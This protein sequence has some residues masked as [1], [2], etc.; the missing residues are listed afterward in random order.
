MEFRKVSFLAA[1]ALIGS[2][3]LAQPAMAEQ[4]A[5]EV[6]GK[7]GAKLTGDPEKGK[8]VFNQCKACHTLEPGKNLTGPTLHGIIGRTAG[9]VE[10]YNYSTANKES[11]VVWTEQNMF[12][13]L[14]NPR[15]W[16]KGTKMAFAGLRKEQDRAD[17][18]A[19]IQEE[20]KGEEADKSAEEG[21]PA[22]EQKPAEEAAP[23]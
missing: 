16:M 17:V 20:S 18:I 5:I 22:E 15:E 11:G 23:Q 21:K 8:A 7:D 10:G 9:T 6:T 13:Y 4:V 12:E 19:Y 2:F 3:A 1:A 14:E